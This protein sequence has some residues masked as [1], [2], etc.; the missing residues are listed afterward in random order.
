[1]RNT[2]RAV[3]GLLLLLVFMQ[4]GSG[5]LAQERV[6]AGIV[7]DPAGSRLAGV[8]VFITIKNGTV[9]DEQGTYSLH[10]PDE[11]VTITA[12]MIGFAEFRQTISAKPGRNLLNISLHPSDELLDDVVITAGKGI[13]RRQE[14][15]VSME[16]IKPD[17]L[18]IAAPTSMEDAIKITPGLNIAD[19]Q[20]S[21]RSGAGYSYGAGSR[22]LLLYN[23]LPMLSADA[24]DIKWNLI[25]MND[26]ERVEVIKGA[27]SS[28]YGS[29]AMNGVIN[30]ISSWP[31][32]SPKTTVSLQGGIYLKPQRDELYWY[33][34]S[35]RYLESFSFMHSRQVGRFDLQIGADQ[36]YTTRYRTFTYEKRQNINWKLRYRSKSVTGLNFGLGM[37]S[38]S[39]DASGFFLWENAQEGAYLQDS[40]LANPVVS[41]RVVLDPFVNYSQHGWNH[42]LKGR[43]YYNFNDNLDDQKDNRFSTVYLEYLVNHEFKSDIKFTA[44][45]NSTVSK[46]TANLFGNHTS[47][48]L[49]FFSQAEKLFF[50]KLRLLAGLRLEGFRLDDESEFSNPLIRLGL[51][52]ELN[53]G[54]NLRASFGQAFRYPT[55]AEKFTFTQVGA[56]QILPNPNLL[57]ETGYNTEIGYRQEFMIRDC[58]AYVDAAIFQTIY[59]NMMEF[60]FGVV[61]SITFEPIYDISQFGTN[62]VGFQAR[63]VGEA[64]IDGLEL[65]AGASYEQGDWNLDAI[66]GYTYTLPIDENTDSLYRAWKSEDSNMLKYRYKHAFNAAFSCK[67]KNWNLSYALQYNSKIEVI[68]KFFELGIILPGLKEYRAT[69]DHGYLNQ[70]I[71]LSRLFGKAIEAGIT[72]RNLANKEQMIRPGDLVAPTMVMIQLKA[73]F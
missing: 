38:S 47:S 73:A 13:N 39:Q 72:V 22:V 64:K 35:L 66:A 69:Y 1:M 67:Y 14:V 12:R 49:A 65:S 58:K 21:I 70:D 27:S 17:L 7:S 16:L 52:Y 5:V 29:G 15:V 45:I 54:G 60:T 23:G 63:N 34:D 4:G 10:C 30:V 51:N 31:G 20:A 3:F 61:D 50:K 24:G 40:S 44:G 59:R 37:I 62:P 8:H 56:L 19:G 43:Y 11:K 26:V 25:P 42:S 53:K 41:N 57:S 68:D 55:I 28:L 48:G 71:S 9:S 6:I 46:A 36:L 18:K 33:K 2:I 32:S